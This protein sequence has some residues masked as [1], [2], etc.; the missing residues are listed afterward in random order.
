MNILKAH[1]R[2]QGDCNVTALCKSFLRMVTPYYRRFQP[3]DFFN[4]RSV[5]GY[6]VTTKA[7]PN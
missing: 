1:P 5:E 2:F 3:F 7:F 4:G 6:D